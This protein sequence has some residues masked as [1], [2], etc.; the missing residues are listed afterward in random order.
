MS[1]T[2]SGDVSVVDVASRKVTATFK[3]GPSPRRL[4]TG[5]VVTR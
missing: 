2:G 1:N 4:A 5:A 3:V